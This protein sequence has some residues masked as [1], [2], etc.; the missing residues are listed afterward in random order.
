MSRTIPT[1]RVVV[2]CFAVGGS[3]AGFAYAMIAGFWPTWQDYTLNPQFVDPRFFLI[4]YIGFGMG[5][6][7]LFGLFV[8][9]VAAGT[10]SLVGRR[11]SSAP[12]LFLVGA[13]AVLVACFL[14]D[15]SWYGVRAIPDGIRF[16]EYFGPAAVAYLALIWLVVHLVRRRRE[17]A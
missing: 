5:F 11:T 10:S 17:R 13:I 4:F 2:P 8:G 1:W 7:G 16:F 12:V 9:G 15:F 6:G 3:L 14:C